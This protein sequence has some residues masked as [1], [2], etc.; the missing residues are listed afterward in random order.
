M[1]RPKPLAMRAVLSALA[2][3]TPLA[4]AAIALLFT[5]QIGLGP[6]I[7]LWLIATAGMAVMLWRSLNDIAEA[8]SFFGRIADGET[9]TVPRLASIIDGEEMETIGIRLQRRLE[10]LTATAEDAG[11]LATAVLDALPDPVLQLSDERSITRTN[12]AARDLFGDGI[13]GRS[14]TQVLRSPPVQEAVDMVLDGAVS[15]SVE[16]SL[17]SPVEREFACRVV[18]LP[19][20]ARDG[21]H[22][23]LSLRDFT[24]QRRTEQMRADFVANASHEI[25]TPLATLSGCIETLQGP[26]RDDEEAIDRFLQIMATQSTRMTRLVEDLLSLS[27]IELNEHTPPTGTVDLRAVIDRVTDGLTLKAD[28]ANVR[29]DITMADDLPPALG[30]MNELEQVVQ[31]LV[32]NAIKYGGEGEIRIEATRADRA[33]PGI[34]DRENALMIRIQDQGPGIAREHLPRLT[35][36]FYRVDTAR[37]R[38]LGGT[39]LGLAIVKHIVNR[40]RGVLTVDSRIGDGSTFTVYLPAAPA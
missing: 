9:A 20:P 25:R 30:D 28:A 3:S 15:Q 39:G 7:G 8:G 4:A 14:L 1:Y 6:A 40:H 16:F 33:L 10:A 24:E 27:R 5:G 26:G 37:S 21:T 32:D 29:V 11:M 18:R 23:V 19:Q 12:R 31:N 35:E 2:L 36:R 13:E 38:E 34:T 22:V 17:P